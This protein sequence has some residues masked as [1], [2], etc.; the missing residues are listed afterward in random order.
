MQKK[1]KRCGIDVLAKI[2]DSKS[3]LVGWIKSQRLATH[4]ATLGQ[5]LG[6]ICSAPKIPG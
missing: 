4:E 3:H 5:M 6:L 2:G 1:G